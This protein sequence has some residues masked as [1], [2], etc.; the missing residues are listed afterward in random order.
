MPKDEKKPARKQITTVRFLKLT[1]ESVKDLGLDADT[2]TVADYVEAL[3][4]KALDEM[5]V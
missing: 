3:R 4:D 5:G 1:R 2:T